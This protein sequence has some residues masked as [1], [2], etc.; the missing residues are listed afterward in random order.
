MYTSIYCTCTQL[1][2]M[3]T[4][5]STK[6]ISFACCIYSCKKLYRPGS[7]TCITWVDNFYIMNSLQL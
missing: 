3:C 2:L 6:Y 4:S 7:H 1:C 5:G